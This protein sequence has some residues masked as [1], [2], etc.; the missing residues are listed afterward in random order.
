MKGGG[1]AV[2]GVSTPLLKRQDI[3]Q[4]QGLLKMCH[5]IDSISQLIATVSLTSSLTL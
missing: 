3:S 5:Y 2:R 4:K 1:R